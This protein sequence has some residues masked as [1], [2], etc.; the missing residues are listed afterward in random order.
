ME[1]HHL[2]LSVVPEA[3]VAS[4]LPAEEF[5]RYLA[6]GSHKRSSG[7]AIYFE[8]DPDFSSEFF[9]M[10]I[11]PERCVAHADGSPKRSLYLGVY[12]VM[13]HIPLEVLGKLYLTT[14]DGQVLV[15]EQ[16]ELP[17]AFPDAHYLYDELCP[18]H[19][20]IASK[21]DPMV[22][23]KFATNPGSPLCV[24]KIFFA[25][26]D[27]AAIIGAD[28]TAEGSPAI[29]NLPARIKE[30]FEELDAVDKPSKTADRTRQLTFRWNHIKNG[31]YIGDQDRLLY[32]PFPS[33]EAL[34]RNHHA[35]WR[36]ATL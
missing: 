21:F 14:R 9:N 11:V 15:L 25:Q 8:I 23:T 20:L 31:Y 16:G 13:E 4:M 36:S 19:P 17:T 34:G 26:L 3:L 18:V 24:P 29:H 5:G 2:Y 30:C 32:Y 22:F 28:K 7:V 10:G 35:W 27:P 6:V 1:K 33:V 12:R